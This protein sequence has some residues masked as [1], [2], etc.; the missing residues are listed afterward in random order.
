[1][2]GVYVAFHY[3]HKYLEGDFQ[4]A[5]FPF[6]LDASSATFATINSTSATPGQALLLSGNGF[7]SAQGEV[8][9]VVGPGKDLTASIDSW[10]DSQILIHVPD[11]QGIPANVT[12][13][14][15]VKRHDG[16]RSNS[17]SFIF[18]PLMVH[19]LID[20][21]RYLTAATGLA[22]LQ[23]SFQS[24]NNKDSWQLSS[25]NTTLQIH[26]ETGFFS[27]SSGSDLA[28]WACD[29]PLYAI[30]MGITPT[31]CPTW[32]LKNGWTVFALNWWQDQPNEHHEV[33]LGFWAFITIR[34][35]TPYSHAGATP[36]SP[37]PCLQTQW[38]LFTTDSGSQHINYSF[39]IEIYG[40]KGCDYF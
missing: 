10:S 36:P 37:D 5:E 33:Y 1:V 15:F 39:S 27:E 32:C 13:I 30:P 16:A 12:G 35:V 38:D 11:Y 3:K 19:Q 17:L 8:H 18:A 22:A 2:A 23:W 20:L 28:F 40:P 4:G 7:A 34:T 25:D 26:H 29:L 9:C 31:T 6:I 14:I 24:G 21:S